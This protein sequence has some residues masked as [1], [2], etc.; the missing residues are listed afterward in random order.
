MVLQELRPKLTLFAI[1]VVVA[2]SDL[3]VKQYR[4][5]SCR[6]LGVIIL[7]LKFGNLLLKGGLVLFRQCRGGDLDFLSS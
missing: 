3:I 1:P 6:R 7:A 4:D 2:V 5:I